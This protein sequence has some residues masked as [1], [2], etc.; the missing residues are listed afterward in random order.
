MHGAAPYYPTHLYDVMLNKH[1]IV[2]FKQS[3]SQKQI[4]VAAQSQAR[5]PRDP[6]FYS[7]IQQRIAGASGQFPNIA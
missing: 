4:W 5:Q 7:R 2:N 3:K 1:N 6:G